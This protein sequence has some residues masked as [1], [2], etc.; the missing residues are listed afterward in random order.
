MG[1]AYGHLQ[2]RLRVWQG[3]VERY[4][5]DI[6]I[7]TICA[8]RDDQAEGV[9]LQ[10]IKALLTAITCPTC[11]VREQTLLLAVRAVY[12]IYLVSR[13][14]VNKNTAKATLRQMLNYVSDRMEK[15]AQRRRLAPAPGS[16]ASGATTGAAATAS[17][18][19]GA[20]EGQDSAA[21]DAAEG[22]DTSDQ[23]AFGAAAEV[24]ALEAAAAVAAEVEAAEAAEAERTGAPHK[25]QQHAVLNPYTAGTTA[26]AAPAVEEAEP[27]AEAGAAAD[28]ALQTAFGGNM[29]PAVA[30]HLGFTLADSVAVAAAAPAPAPDT[31]DQAEASTQAAA[32]SAAAPV[33]GAGVGMPPRAASDAG[34][35]ATGAAAGFLPGAFHPASTSPDAADLGGFASPYHRDAFLLFRAVCRLSMKGD[36]DPLLP[37]GARHLPGAGP[38]PVAARRNSGVRAGD[39]HHA[40]SLAS[41]TASVLTDEALLND[42]VALSSKL[43]ALDLVLSML[44]GAGAAFRSDPKFIG[45]IKQYLCVGLLKNI[46]SSIPAVSSSSLKVF[47]ALMRGFKQHIAAEIEVFISAVFLRLLT[48][49]HSSFEQKMAVLAAFRSITTDPAAMLEIFLNYDCVDGRQ[50]LFESSVNV[51]ASIAQG[52]ASAEFNA[53]QKTVA[54]TV[55]IR[56]AALGALASIV[57]SM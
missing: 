7:E 54:E 32:T 50:N 24:A 55:A 47:L 28:A 21:S 19:S 46:L 52:R 29:Y 45:A 53:S 37:T 36:E 12:H 15:F 10:V 26:A 35:S 38:Q 48:S 20:G 56:S 2:G 49:A 22:V 30:A 33:P 1:A 44:E 43:L 25:E 13:N 17:S 9:Q 11:T 34:S 39:A 51:L 8:S 14:A 27:E 31:H 5:I 40:S 41:S 42:P 6:V 3:S 4:L 23:P 18:G 57:Q 16:S